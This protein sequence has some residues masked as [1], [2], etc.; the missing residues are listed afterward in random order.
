MHHPSIRAQG[1]ALHRPPLSWG[2]PSTMMLG[3]ES[4]LSTP[5]IDVDGEHSKETRPYPSIQH[6]TQH[7]TR[8]PVVCVPSPPLCLAVVCWG[9]CGR[10]PFTSSARTHARHTSSYT[11]PVDTPP[12]M[13][14]TDYTHGQTDRRTD[15]TPHHTTQ[16]AAYVANPVCPANRL[17]LSSTQRQAGRQACRNQRP[18]SKQQTRP[19]TRR[20]RRHPSIHPSVNRPAADHSLPSLSLRKEPRTSSPLG[21]C[22]VSCRVDKRCG[23]LDAAGRGRRGCARGRWRLDGGRV[24]GRPRP[25]DG[26][27]EGAGH[28]TPQEG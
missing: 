5:G 14:P 24:V 22:L 12:A 28:H 9:G 16:P 17:S 18:K 25:C 10:R 13:K 6:K 8:T 27:E 3:V 4:E 2:H 19:R 20:W 23:R 15:T 11:R 26:Q 21:G 1:N 7:Q